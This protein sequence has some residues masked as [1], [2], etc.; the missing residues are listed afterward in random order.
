M[1]NW[2]QMAIELSKNY[3]KDVKWTEIEQKIYEEY[4]FAIN[5]ERIRSFCRRYNKKYGTKYSCKTV[6]NTPEDEVKKYGERVTY[7][8]DGS[9][10]K[11][12][13]V[14]IH[15]QEDL[16]PER[17]I[18]LHGLNPKLYKMISYCSNLWNG[19][20]KDGANNTLYQSKITV[21]PIITD[22]TVKEIDEYFNNKVFINS[23]PLTT[24]E[25]Y[26]SVGEVL[27]ICIPD[28]HA[29]LLAWRKETGKDYDLKIAKQNFR[30]GINDII[31][32]CYNRTFSKI[33]FV[34]LGDLLHT[35]NDQN[36]TT[37]G[38][39]QNVD[40]RIA[41]IFSETLDLLI[42]AITSLGNIAPVEVVYIGGN[43]DLLSGYTL[44]KA[45][46]MAFRNDD[47][48][49]FDTDPNPQK[50]RLIGV[51]LVG[52]CHG[53]MPL[54]NMSS[55]L[56]Q[57]A[58]VEFGQSKYA[59]VHSAHF[60]SEKTNE[61]RQTQEENGI[62]VRWLPSICSSSL[63]EHKQGY[64]NTVSTVLSFVW[65]PSLGLRETWYSTI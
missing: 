9:I 51:N 48:V 18:E 27:E 5:S 2:Q 62:I 3:A 35:D 19:M 21:K 47:N 64:S 36:T 24:Y 12:K 25:Q 29:G 41:K 39:F 53:D 31:G 54:K 61:Y 43:H 11:D 13:L 63:W 44:L 65:N 8:K 23:K 14:F 52:W 33:L 1:L 37:K 16:K 22:V 10:V 60:H 15:S 17:L 46:E 55:W 34:T 26:S 20:G 40:G 42:E 45:T 57:R 56:Q 7:N 38:T 58:R 59:E 32:R 4:H 49:T 28:L 6:Q 50:Y 30:K